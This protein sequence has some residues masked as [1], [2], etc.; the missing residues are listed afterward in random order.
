MGRCGE[1]GSENHLDKSMQGR[2]RGATAGTENWKDPLEGKGR[3]AS[4]D[5]TR[6]SLRWRF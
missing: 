3:K 6:I 2:A 1:M 5:L 4:G